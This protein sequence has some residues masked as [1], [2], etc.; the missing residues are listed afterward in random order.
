MK[1]LQILN[2]SS[3]G[4][5]R[6][7]TNKAMTKKKDKKQVMI[8]NTKHKAKDLVL[9]VFGPFHVIRRSGTNSFL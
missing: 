8:Q 9:S 4:V 3:N 5:S 2:E 7:D 6:R 1:H